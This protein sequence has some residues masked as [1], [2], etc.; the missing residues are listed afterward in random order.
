MDDTGYSNHTWTGTRLYVPSGYLLV[1]NTYLV[2]LLRLRKNKL[3]KTSAMKHSVIRRSIFGTV[4][5]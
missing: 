1:S 5:F 3:R 4:H 2:N